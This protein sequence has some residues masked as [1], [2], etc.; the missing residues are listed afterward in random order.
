MKWEL[1]QLGTLKNLG[2]SGDYQGKSGFRAVGENLPSQ[3]S[4]FLMPVPLS[5]S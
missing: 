1:L 3:T 2:M 5:N 4:G